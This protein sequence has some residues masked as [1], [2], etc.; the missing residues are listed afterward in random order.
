M[1]INVVTNYN[2]VSGLGTIGYTF[3]SATPDVVF[4]YDQATHYI[5]A[6]KRD[7]PIVVGFETY[8]LM[9]SEI[10]KYLT[11]CL[12]FW[13]LNLYTTPL[14]TW[15]LSLDRTAI[16]AKMVGKWGFFKSQVDWDGSTITLAA[17]KA[18]DMN[19]DD[20]NLLIRNHEHLIREIRPWM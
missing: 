19:L 8:E 17:R 4:T 15:D 6:P 3:S 1:A 2:L 14:S 13:T 18:V 12:E 16:S 20:F 9:I 10:R 5:T 7:D 11:R